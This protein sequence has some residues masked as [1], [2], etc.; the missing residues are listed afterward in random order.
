MT[1]R[2][3]SLDGGG[4]WALLQAKALDQLYPGKSG[5]QILAEFDLVAANSGGSIVLGGLIK[6]L[7]PAAIVG[8]FAQQAV[9]DTLFVRVWLTGILNQALGV[10]PKYSTEGK[11]K[12]LAQ[13]LG[14]PL[15]DTA[16]KDLVLPRR[17]G[18]PVKVFIVGFD[19]DQQRATFFRSYQS[20]SGLL[21]ADLSLLDAI[22]A[23]STAPVNFFDQPATV[24]VHRYWDGGVSGYNNPVMGA[25]VEAMIDGAAPEAIQALSLGTGTV[26]LAPRDAEGTPPDE[27][28][29]RLDAPGPLVDIQKLAVSILDD[30]PDAASYTAYIAL[31]ND[32]SPPSGK[33][34]G[35]VVRLSPCIQPVFDQGRRSWD[36]PPGLVKD[37]ADLVKLGMDATK[38]PDIDRLIQLGDAWIA[39]QVPN[40]PVRI[41][42]KTLDCAVGDPTFAQGAASWRKLTEPGPAPGPVA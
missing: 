20:R 9:R 35:S 28:R 11:R 22:H 31:G 33:G 19:Y 42:W 41:G 40:Q 13:V 18:T 34:S 30:P 27:L 39:G 14:S 1:Y 25:V 12:G 5:H 23:S 36:L 6:D 24:G 26:R 15:A 21:A 3:L 7:T 2:I 16:M 10:L 29:Q 17:N 32:P 8:I 37:F 4:S 38:Q